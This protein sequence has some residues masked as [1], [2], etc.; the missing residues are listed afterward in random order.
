MSGDNDASDHRGQLP[1]FSPPKFNWNQ[2]NLYKQFKSLK[3]VVEFTFQGHYKK[4]SNGIKCGLILNWLGVE[5]YPT[6]DNL[7]ISEEDKKDP[8]KLL[9]AFEHYFKPERNIFQS[10]YASGSIYSGAF[11]T[12]SEFYHKLNSV[13]NDCNFTNKDEIVKFLYLTHNQNT[14]VHEHLLKELTDTT[15]LANMLRMAIVCEGTVNSEEISKQYLESVKTVKQVDAIH[16][17]NSSKPKHKGRGHGG[18]RSH[19]SSQ[20]GKPGGCLNCGSSHPH[21]K[22]KA[23]GKECFHCHKK[24]NFSQFCHSKQ[25]GKSPRSNVRSSS[26]NN[27]FSCSDIHEIDQSQFDDSIQFEQDSITIQFKTKTR[28]TNLMFDEISSIP[29]L[30]GVLTD[31]HVKPMGS[32]HWAKQCFKIDS[33]ACGNLMPLSMYKSMYN[34]VPSS[35]TVNNVVCLLDYN[36]KEIKQF[37]ACDVDVRFRSI[38]KHIHFYVVPDRLK[39]IIGVSD[40]LTLGLTSIHCPIYTDWQSNLANSVDSIHANADSTVLLYS[41]T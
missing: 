3:R 14:R 31:V 25:H 6:Y 1:P 41:G 2:D 36:K 38:V 28:H 12:Q 27:R 35:T 30:Q 29:S 13:A 5:A 26:Q 20:S 32:S 22:C 39:P 37:G 10:W 34:H 40:A 15:S 23:N 21:K 16:Q 19:S 4:C 7:P 17:R 24:G 8:T 18:H 11:K 9:D 33:G